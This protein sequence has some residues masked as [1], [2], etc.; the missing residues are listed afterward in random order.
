[1]VTTGGIKADPEKIRALIN[2]PSLSYDDE[3]IFKWTERVEKAL[4]DVKEE[5]D[6]VDLRYCVLNGWS[7]VVANLREVL[8]L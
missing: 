2:R 8:K 1:M 7:P 3:G 6:L 4:Q 5:M